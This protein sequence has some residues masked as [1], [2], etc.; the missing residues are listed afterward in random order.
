MYK[1]V[2][3]LDIYITQTVACSSATHTEPFMA[4]PL[5]QWLC[6]R[7]PMLR[8]HTLPIS[9]VHFC[10][11]G[12]SSLHPDLIAEAARHFRHTQCSVL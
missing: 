5:R 7:A 11:E 9:S 6:E 12:S 4:F 8:L 1:N 10:D 3:M 2:K